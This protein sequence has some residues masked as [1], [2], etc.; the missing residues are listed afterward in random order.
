MSGETLRVAVE[1]G[2]AVLEMT[3][4]QQ[5]NSFDLPAARAFD[6]AV[7]AIELDD[8]VRVVLLTGAGKRFCAGGDVAS[9]IAAEGRAA[10]L[11]E[12][13][14]V[15]DGALQH[16]GTLSKP[17][18]VAVQ[19]AVAGAG[20]GV[21]LAGDIIVA[22]RAT[23]FVSAYESIGL[24]PDCGVSWLLPRVIGQQ[25]A[26]QFC[27]MPAAINAD[28]ALSWGLITEVVDDD[29]AGRAL[30]IARSLAAGPAQALGQ[31][32]RLLRSSWAADRPTSGADEAR[33][34]A[35]AVTTAEATV[36]VEAFAQR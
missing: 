27:L 18:V 14:E 33:T 20:I 16:L 30:D 7:R 4:Q 8:A 10:Y 24:T 29:A 9:M 17:V 34:I 23:K 22:D 13:A 36:L 19:G 26:L 11:Q 35:N 6:D 28:I 5:S 32:R 1:D 2:V 21:M 31:A 3:R 15:L 12:L 25:R